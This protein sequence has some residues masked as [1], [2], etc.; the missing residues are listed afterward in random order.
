[1]FS[2]LFAFNYLENSQLLAIFAAISNWFSKKRRCFFSSITRKINNY[3][4]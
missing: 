4:Y 3:K 2:S 1:M